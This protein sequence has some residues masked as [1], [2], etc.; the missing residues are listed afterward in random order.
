[1]KAIALFGKMLAFSRLK[2]N[3]DDIA[4]IYHELTTTFKKS[5]GSVPVVIDSAVDLDLT[6]L[7]D[8]LW[9]LNIQPIGVMDGVLTE[10]AIKI[11]LAVFPA[12]GQRIETLKP[13][14]TTEPSI[15]AET[16][17]QHSLDTPAQG[18]SVRVMNDEKDGLNSCVCD[19]ML[20]SGQS[21]QHLGGDLA[22]LGGVNWGAE[23]ITDS[24]LH[25]YGRGFGR[26]VAGATG[27]K[28]ARIFCQR[29]N[30]SL[31]SVAGTYCLHDDIPPQFI[32]KP[33]QVSYDAEEGLV[34][35]LMDN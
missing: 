26:L 6:A 22:I 5:A 29:F 25:V 8:V 1:M 16:P 28:K 21:F 31:V 27:D 3:T 34:F 2:I 23:A 13:E 32:D 35:A 9:S 11:R 14:K 24:N 19:G 17:N 30:P 15:L 33:V 12:D 10:Q 18:A 7:V 4:L 20:R